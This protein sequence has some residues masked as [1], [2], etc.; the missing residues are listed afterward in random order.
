MMATGASSGTFRSFRDERAGGRE[1]TRRMAEKGEAPARFGRACIDELRLSR[2]HLRRALRAVGSSLGQSGSAARKAA[3]GLSRWFASQSD[4]DDTFRGGRDLRLVD[5][6][7]QI[8]LRKFTQGG[9]EG[10]AGIRKKLYRGARCSIHREG[11]R[12]LLYDSTSPAGSAPREKREVLHVTII[13][14]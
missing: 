1:F 13:G 4:S 6:R 12:S 7:I 14:D 5:R 10:A 11:A 8:G 9:N 3:I 2:V